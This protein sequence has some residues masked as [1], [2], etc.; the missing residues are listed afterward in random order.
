MKTRR[1]TLVVSAVAG[2]VV[3][4]AA[5]GQVSDKF[6]DNPVLQSA[7]NRV[8]PVSGGGTDAGG[9]PD[10]IVG[11][12]E[13]TGS[14]DTTTSSSSFVDPYY[15]YGLGTTSCNIST[16]NSNG[17]NL[18]W[19]SNTPFHPII[20]QNMYRLKTVNGATRFEQI[21]Y[22]WS[23][24]A[25][26][27]LTQNVC[28]IGC[29]GSGGSVLGMGCSDPYTA[30]RNATQSSAGPRYECNPFTGVFPDS[31]AVRNAWPATTDGT[32]RR[33]RVHKDDFNAAL[34]PGALYFG[35]AIYITRDDA[36]FGNSKNNAS[37]RRFTVNGN[38]TSITLT[39]SQGGGLNG[40]QRT[41]PAIFAW[42]DHGNGV[43]TP[44]NS[45][46]IT[47]VSCGQTFFS[48]PAYPYNGAQGAGTT[49]VT[50]DG[51]GW[52]YVASKATDLG[53]GFWNYEYAV[54]NLNSD[55]GVGSF[56]VNI[57]AGATVSNIEM[58]QIMCHSGSVADDANRNAAWTQTNTG[59][60]LVWASPNTWNAAT[61]TLGSYIRWGTMCNFR[62]I[63]NVAPASNGSVTLGYYK[64]LTGYVDTITAAAHVPGAP[65]PAA[66]YANCDQS[67]GSPLLTANDFQCF[68]NKFAAGDTYANC[69][70]STGTPLLTA[71]DFQCFLNKFAAGCT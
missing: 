1:S 57:P 43:N 12:I 19:R 14:G 61:P 62:F 30:S 41:K 27:A 66:C 69:D 49:L 18:L 23:K 2:S 70:G 26:T 56:R 50:P 68:L 21:G 44:D 42:R 7:L 60:Q 58:R 6:A 51:D 36:S 9:G 28:S 39:G 71:N 55:R 59:S 48:Q 32:S 33:L 5:H 47:E 10:V 4:A 64:P 53:G 34:N 67:S 20:P 46:M 8:Y 63:A 13:N 45:V 40:T 24:Y 54:F 38:G 3:S 17:Q 52:I 15:A 22:S 16:V 11:E 37:Y 35:E 29:N 25:F 31:T 65:P